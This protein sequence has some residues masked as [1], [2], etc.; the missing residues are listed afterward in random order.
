MMSKYIRS[1]ANSAINRQAI[2]C[3]F[4]LFILSFIY[5]GCRSAQGAETTPTIRY[6]F[7][8]DAKLSGLP[9]N[10]V[11]SLFIDNKHKELY[12]LDDSNHRVVITDLE[13]TFLYQFDYA[14][15]GVKSAPVGFAVAE[16]GL[17][18]FA[19]EKRIIIT[20]Y[21]GIYKRDISL[22]SIPNL[23]TMSIQSIAID[24][25]KIY[26]GDSGNNRV[27]VMDRK[28]E[29][30]LTQFIAQELGKNIYIAAD[31]D[32]I[33]IRNPSLFSVLHL[34][35]NGKV[36]NNFGKVSSL[37][38]GF[39]MTADITID[40]KNGWVIVVDINRLMVIFF[41]RQGKFLFEFGGPMLFKLPRAAAVDDKNRV[42]VFDATKRIRVFQVIEPAVVA[43]PETEPAPVIAVKPETKPAPP[44]SPKPPMDEV[45]AMAEKELRLLPV[46]FDKGSNDLKEADLQILA[47]NAEWLKKNP[48]VKIN[49]RGYADEQATYEYNLAISEDRAKVVLQYLVQQGIDSKRLNFTNFGMATDKGEDALR[50]KNRVDLL[51]VK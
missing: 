30:F 14:D 36:L 26:I 21:R 13:G 32:G 29:V 38:G 12:A 19:E 37:P 15:A 48:A 8:I 6:L 7:S 31:Y 5:P 44:P 10:G 27:I 51:V 41:D 33:Y 28:N 16:D 42:Y 49:I 23:D 34:D 46:F 40:R 24:E 47:K 25:D 3:F 22:F 9:L 50:Q 39:S 45:S 43:K 20:T 17:L 2:I 11:Q 4:I 1:E 18:Y 35:K